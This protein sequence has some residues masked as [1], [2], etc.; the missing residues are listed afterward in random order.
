MPLFALQRE[1]F[2]SPDLPPLSKSGGKG[3]ENAVLPLTQKG[4]PVRIGS[5]LVYVGI[6]DGSGRKTAT[7][8]AIPTE[9]KNVCGHE[10]LPG[11]NCANAAWVN[12]VRG[13]KQGNGMQ[14]M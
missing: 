9:Q 12:V 11:D 4:V 2:H 3:E 6:L 14:K 1:K 13:K 10:N 7:D 5:D 8:G